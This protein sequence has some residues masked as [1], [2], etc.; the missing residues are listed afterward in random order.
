L[1]ASGQLEKDVTE[2][3][4]KAANCLLYEAD[5][6]PAMLN[7]GTADEP[8]MVPRSE[9]WQHAYAQRVLLACDGDDAR[10]LAAAR[11][12]RDEIGSRFKRGTQRAREMARAADLCDQAASMVEQAGAITD[13]KARRRLVAAC[14]HE[15]TVIALGVFPGVV[16]DSAAD[17]IEELREIDEEPES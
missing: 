13:D 11:Q 14:R 17:L 9:A 10:L 1:V 16:E 15:G 2:A 7:V 5:P 8:R 4:S 12:C 6:G 3:W